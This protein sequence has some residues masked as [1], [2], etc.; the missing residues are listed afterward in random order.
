MANKIT[1]ENYK[2]V[3]DKFKIWM[4]DFEKNNYPEAL[5]ATCDDLNIF[6]DELLDNDA[7]GTEGQLD[8]RGDQRS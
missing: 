2:E 6:F 8:P 4:M 5:S 1:P 7:F 3:L